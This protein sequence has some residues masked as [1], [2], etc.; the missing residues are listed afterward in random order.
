MDDESGKV[1]RTRAIKDVIIILILVILLWIGLMIFDDAS[2]LSKWMEKHY[3]LFIALLL[4]M[5]AF[6]IFSLRRWSE[7]REEISWRQQMNKTLQKQ[8]RIL[9]VIHDA[10]I[11]MD[12]ELVIQSWNAGAERL[13][14]YTPDEAIGQHIRMTCF[15]E[16]WPEHVNEVVEQLQEKGVHEMIWRNRRKNGEENFVAL[17][18][19]ILRDENGMP[20]TLI[21]CSNDIT[22]LRESEESLRVVM[23]TVPDYIVALDQ[24]GAVLYINRVPPGFN[25]DEVIGTRIAEYLEPASQEIRNQLVEQVIRTGEKCEAELA[26]IHSRTYLTRFI[27]LKDRGQKV[28]VLAVGTDISGHKQTEAQL[29]DSLKEN[30]VMLKELQHRVKN[31]LQVVASL[32]DLRTDS[33]QDKHAIDTINECRN[34]IRSLALVYENLYAANGLSQIN[35]GDHIRELTTYLFHSYGANSDAITLKFNADHILMSVDKAIPCSLIINEL[36]SNSLTHAF[37]AGQKGEIG[38]DLRLSGDSR[39]TVIVKDTGVGI[40]T[41]VDFRNPQSLGL[42]LVKRLTEQLE[43]EIELERT[44][45]T[46]FKIVFQSDT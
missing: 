41:N 23:E 38:I 16:D 2:N 35:L 7:L 46:T 33:I 34:S 12:M 5:V 24:D 17:R 10:V 20:I 13:F 11:S 8:A 42:R 30:K 36:V 29:K 1:H 14:G 25:R 6:V 21:G 19:S 27:P 32:L 15:P 22:K 18:L 44:G 31:S 4:M 45:G 3:N 43:G 40:P 9:D 39:A 37:P 26:D 28:R